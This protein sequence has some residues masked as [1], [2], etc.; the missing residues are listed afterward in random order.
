MKIKSNE[1]KT[2]FL[3]ESAI[4]E[5]ADRAC[6]TCVAV[7]SGSDKEM[8]VQIS[9]GERSV[10]KFICIFVGA[11]D[12]DIKLSVTSIHLKSHSTSE[13]IV[14]GVLAGTAKCLVKGLIRMDK[15]VTASSGLF[16]QRTLLLSE[17][18]SAK[19]LPYLEIASYNVQVKHQVAIS[20][21]DKEQ[22]FYL[23]S[24]GIKEKEA[25]RL[26]AEGLFAKEQKLLSPDLQE[27]LTA[28]L[29]SVI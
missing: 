5:V 22:L 21:I 10:Y 2:V 4:F 11:G 17:R 15:F 12:D 6:L 18:A 13:I 14:K 16:S 1:S 26:I 3:S 24:R 23:M 20:Y 9:L 8:E 28:K 25:S 27:K 29:Q 19:S 7:L